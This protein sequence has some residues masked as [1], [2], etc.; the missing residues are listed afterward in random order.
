MKAAMRKV[1]FPFVGYVFILTGFVGLGLFVA[2]LA[3][4]M[5]AALFLGIATVAAYGAGTACF[6]YRRSQMRGAGPSDPLVFHFDPMVP[7]TDRRNVARYLRT[8]RGVTAAE[9]ST[10]VP[11]PSARRRSPVLAARRTAQVRSVV[12]VRSFGNAV[13]H[14]VL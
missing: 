11:S 7:N 9:E 5:A 1:P 10:S 2:A 12:S 13:R 4:G 6:L 3:H 14:T 8:Y